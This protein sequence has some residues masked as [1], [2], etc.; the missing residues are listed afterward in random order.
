MMW[1]LRVNPSL[2]DLG[3]HLWEDWARSNLTLICCLLESNQKGHF[4]CMLGSGGVNMCTMLLW[5]WMMRCW[6]VWSSFCALGRYFW[7]CSVVKV[8]CV[9]IETP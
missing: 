7:S 4:R 2:H 6:I 5:D 3:G 9:L 1:R 8:E